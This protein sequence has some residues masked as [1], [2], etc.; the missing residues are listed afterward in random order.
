M[1]RNNIGSGPQL[2][3]FL[4]NLRQVFNLVEKIWVFRQ[5]QI[6]GCVETSKTDGNEIVSLITGVKQGVDEEASFI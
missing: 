5:G 6:V 4:T 1:Q 3:Y 2:N